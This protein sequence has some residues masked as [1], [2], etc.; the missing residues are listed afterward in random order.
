MSTHL[1]QR[2]PRLLQ[3]IST[4][5]HDVRYQKLIAHLTKCEVLVLDDLLISSLLQNDP[6][7]LPEIVVDRYDRKVTIV[8]N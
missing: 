1:Y 4:A 6:K 7:E 2:L 5:R 8:T 3:D